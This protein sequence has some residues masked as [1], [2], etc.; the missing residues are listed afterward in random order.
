[1]H[2]PTSAK[3]TVRIVYL[4][5]RTMAGFIVVVSNKRIIPFLPEQ[6][7]II[8]DTLPDCDSY[9]SASFDGNNEPSYRWNEIPPYYTR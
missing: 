4:V 6:D 2:V 1:M 5:L 9:N 3:V 8:D 7:L